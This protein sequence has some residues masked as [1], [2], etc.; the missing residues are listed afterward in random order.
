MVAGVT[1]LSAKLL[2]ES[3]EI[4]DNIFMKDMVFS[5]NVYE[6]P[7]TNNFIGSS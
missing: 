3:T 1:H 2:T 4:S 6:K 5:F 7:G